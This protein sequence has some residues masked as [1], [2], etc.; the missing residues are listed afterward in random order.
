M[1]GRKGFSFDTDAFSG[2]SNL[3]EEIFC[4][5]FRIPINIFSEATMKLTCD[6]EKFS[7]LFSLAAAVVSLK[8]IKA[9]LQNVKMTVS[10][11][12]TILSATDMD[13]SIRLIVDHADIAESGEAIIPT[14]IMKSIL[15]E[16]RAD[17]L[18][19]EAVGDR[20]TIRCDKA[21]F[22]FPTQPVEDFPEI[23]P[24]TAEAYHEVSGT[25]LQEH[26]RRTTFA[27]DTEN[28]KYSLSGVLFELTEG[29]IGTISTD[30]RRLTNQ[31]GVATAFGGHF[32]EG[33]AIVPLKVLGLV[34][35]MISQTKEPVKIHIESGKI[36]FA[37]SNI[38]ISSRLVEGRFPKWKTIIPEKSDRVDVDLMDSD[39]LEG[40][41][42]ADIMTT[43]NQPGVTLSFEPGNLKISASGAGGGD[44]HN[45][46]PISY[47]AEPIDMKLDPRF[48]ID[49]L[50]VLPGDLVLTVYLKERQSILFETK[51][52]Y[53]YI[54]MPLS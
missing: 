8:D 10:D 40:V 52:G 2:S 13:T 15:Q 21:F 24:F 33:T 19:I 45:T 14:R 42:L 29:R 26:I 3:M 4:D 18:E 51:D 39:L 50:R 6:R 17:K 43:E 5:L 28:T 34:E 16:S 41:R 1:C 12:N 20:L 37:T 48:L 22:Q 49:F 7:T 36:V 44:G 11:G 25:T 47:D 31:E 27:I 9:V 54:L 38:V 23:P 53:S 46:L 32:S 30:G 35:K